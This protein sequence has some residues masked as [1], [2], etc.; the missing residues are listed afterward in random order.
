MPLGWER[1]NAKKSSPNQ[2]IVFIKPRPG[3]DES[4][5][6]DYLERIAAQCF[7]VMK[8]HNLAIVSL[9]EYEPNF[10]FWGRNFNSGEVIQLVLKSPSTG[11]WLPFKFVQMVMMHELAHCKQMNHSK[12]FWALRN[13]YSGEM[14]LLWEK[15]YTGEGL[16]GKGILLK[17]G[18]FSQESLDE[19][20]ILPEN[21]CGGTFKSKGARKR[22]A[23][24]K[25]T[26]KE[27][28]ERR[29]RKKFGTNG[30][31]LGADKEVKVQLE[32][33]NRPGCKPRVAGSLR[34]RELR[35]AAALA[36]F[37]VKSAEP[38][39]IQ[40]DNTSSG[41]EIESDS[42]YENCINP[43][44]DDAKD[45]DGKRL[46]DRKGQAMINVCT[47][48][49]KEDPDTKS[50]LSE[51]LKMSRNRPPATS[52]VDPFTPSSDAL[53][54]LKSCNA[55]KIPEVTVHDDKPQLLYSQISNSDEHKRQ[56][57]TAKNE[58]PNH[59]SCPACTFA[60]DKTSLT[61]VVCSNVLRVKLVPNSW[62]CT[63]S[64]CKDDS[65]INAGDVALCGIC[66]MRRDCDFSIHKLPMK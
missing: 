11:R 1:I 62:K 61:C 19:G 4:V 23:K 49:D 9:E 6:K 10:E 13:E 24:V 65:Y 32:K 55:K 41:S 53:S 52:K 46:L 58:S 8:R 48:G 47:G 25:L 51:L 21:M 56:A 29:V 30:I 20:E 50:E 15:G 35:A 42:E 40:D 43:E 17:N 59:T 38:L 14:K 3:P 33:K 54:N 12:A 36:R 18:N 66:A 64:T 5:A 34:G 63:R 28:E 7:P 27:R 31:A 39:V 45:I 2:N 37:D 57:G 22:R 60:N 44:Q 26:Y 16:W